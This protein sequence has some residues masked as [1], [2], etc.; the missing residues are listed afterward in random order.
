MKKL[1]EKQKHLSQR[2]RVAKS[3]KKT[4]DFRFAGLCAFAP[5]REILHFFSHLPRTKDKGP[6]TSSSLIHP[7]HKRLRRQV[8][9]AQVPGQRLGGILAS[10]VPDAHAVEYGVAAIET[11][12][13]HWTKVVLL[14]DLG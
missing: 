14:D 9:L 5:L 3:A 2:R 6:R 4:R 1:S 7:H 10:L 12:D 8:G 13:H 11:L